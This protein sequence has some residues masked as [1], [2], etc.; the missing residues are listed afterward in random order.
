M[1]LKA[2]NGIAPDY[3]SNMFVK[4]SDS[5]SLNLWSVENS[6]LR[7]PFARTSYVESSFAVSGA[8]LWNT[9]PLNLKLSSD[10]STFKYSVKTYL[11]N[12]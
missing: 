4:T 3:L 10:L 6:V 8:R 7:V 9:L 2:L 11:L 1:M 5:H 12:H